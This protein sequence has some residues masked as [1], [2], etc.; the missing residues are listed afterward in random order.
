MEREARGSRLSL[1][2][3]EWPIWAATAALPLALVP[4]SILYY[5]LLLES[6]TLN[7]Q[8]D[9]IAI[10]IVGNAMAAMMVAPF[11]LAITWLCTW[12][13]EGDAD[14]LGWD[15]ARPWRSLAAT[16]VLGTPALGIAGLI[17]IDIASA[18][19]W[20]EYLW[21]VYFGIWAAWFLLLRAVF[22]APRPAR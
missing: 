8:A 14:L 11:V 7:P 21:D 19:A 20:Y 13:Y 18:L 15:G 9:S 16:L 5:R 2:E 1:G 6:G 22:L 17:A 10:P 4:V 12:G 3:R